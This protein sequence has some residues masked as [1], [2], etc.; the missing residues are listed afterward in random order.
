MP[1]PREAI[2]DVLLIRKQ[3]AAENARANDLTTTQAQLFDDWNQANKRARNH[4]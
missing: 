4:A 2:Y 1:H 3:K